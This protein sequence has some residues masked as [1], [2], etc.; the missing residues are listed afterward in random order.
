MGCFENLNKVKKDEKTFSDFSDAKKNKYFF[1]PKKTI[2]DK[3]NRL[4]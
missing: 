1:N 3:G 4:L 2:V